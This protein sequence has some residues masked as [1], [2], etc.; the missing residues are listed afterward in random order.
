MAVFIARRCGF[1][2][3]T[4]ILAS[5]IIFAASQLLPGDIA[6]IMLGQFKTETAV[7][8]LREQ[9]GLNRPAYVQYLDWAWKF[10]RGDWGNSMAF[11]MPVRPILLERL[12]N[13]AMLAGLALILYVPLG[14]V[15][16]VIAALKRDKFT[17]R[18]ISGISMGFVGLPEFVT[19][20]MLISILAIRWNWL[21]ANSSI[22]SG[23]SFREGFRF[24]ILPA[25]TV[26]LTSLG[27]ITRMIRSGTIDVLRADYVRAA[28]LKGLPWRVV[29]FRHVLRNALLP[30]VTVVAMGIG[31]LLGGLIVTEQVFGYPGLGRLIVFSI[32]RGD[33]PMIQAGC[34]IVVS[35]FCLSNLI[36]DILYSLLNP[37]IRVGGK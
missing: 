21:P 17:D 14:A 31:W 35:I 16:G 2:I 37:R 9:L 25:I 28:E 34:M 29:L 33:L 6:S 12:G 7:N 36:A 8:N 10:V 4:L 23:F 11:S 18:A 19:G 13:S 27:Y 1:I 24:L 26:S 30:T 3:L 15:L 32:Q 22:E 5:I 20:L